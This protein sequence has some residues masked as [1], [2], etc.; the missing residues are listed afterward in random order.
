MLSEQDLLQAITHNYLKSPDFNG[1]DSRLIAEVA[2][3]PEEEV[4]QSLEPLV[5]SGSVV[6]ITPDL[7][8]NPA[9]LRLDAPSIERQLEA[10]RS[11]SGE[12][13]WS[14]WAY[15]SPKQLASAVDRNAYAGRPFTLRLALGEPQ[16][17][18]QAFDLR[19]LEFYRNDPR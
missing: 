10:M 1:L 13:W 18:H 6:A 5:L 4:V 14:V 8:D 17:R 3:V 12:R 7:Q 2:H 19:V 16:L 11:P 15:P 9:V